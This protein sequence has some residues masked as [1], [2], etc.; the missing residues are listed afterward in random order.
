[1]L[2]LSN[3]SNQWQSGENILACRR[4]SRAA[5]ADAP[6][7]KVMYR[8]KSHKA[9]LARP[10]DLMSSMIVASYSEGWWDSAAIG[11]GSGN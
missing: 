9:L 11:L 1:M 10:I 2:A 8:Q 4:F 5:D 6:N 7:D 3:F